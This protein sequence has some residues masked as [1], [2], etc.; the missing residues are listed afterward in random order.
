MGKTL[1]DKGEKTQTGRIVSQ[2]LLP[3][4]RGISGASQVVIYLSQKECVALSRYY[5]IEGIIAHCKFN[6]NKI[7]SGIVIG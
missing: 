6:E 7:I 2:Y 4:Q 5:P 1:T 3:E